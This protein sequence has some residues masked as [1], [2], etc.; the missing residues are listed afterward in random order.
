LSRNIQNH[1]T[2]SYHDGT[3]Q[4]QRRRRKEETEEEAHRIALE[5]KNKEEVREEG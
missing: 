1:Q 4:Q 3:L 5:Y 2:A